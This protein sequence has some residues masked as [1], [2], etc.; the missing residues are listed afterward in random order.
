LAD[1]LGPSGQPLQPNPF[2]NQQQQNLKAGLTIDTS[3]SQRAFEDLE[4]LFKKMMRGMGADWDDVS[5]ASLKQQERLYRAIGDKQNEH[6]AMVTRIKNETLAAIEEEKHA[7]LAMLDQRASAERMTQEQ[8]EKE[9]TSIALKADNERKNIEDKTRKNLAKET[10]VGGLIRGKTAEV[11]AA[12]GGPIG[13]LISGAGE[14]LTNPYA[15]G[16]MAIFE[17]FKTKAAFTTTGAQLAGAGFGLGSGAGVGLDFAQKLFG[18]NPFGRL[19]QALSQGEQQ[20][21][22]AQMAG[23]RT[24]VDQ[25]RGGGFTAIRNNLG[26]FANILPDA[27]KDMEIMT[28]ATKNLGMSQ[29]DVTNAFVSSRVN[30]ERLKITQL[31][32]I[33]T[34]MDMAK[35]LRNL[36]ND[37]TVAASTLSNVT[38]YLNAIGASESEKQRIGLSIAQAGAN[39]TLPQMAGMFAFTNGRMPTEH[40]LFGTAATGFGPR[41]QGIVDNP[42]TL[43]GGF[44]AKVGDQFKNNPTARMF[45]ASQLQTQFLPGLRLQDTPRFFELAQDM[46]KGRI[47]Q[48]VFGK[49]FQALEEKTPQVA[50][51]EGIKTLSEIVDPIKRLENVFTNFWTMVDDK[52]NMVLQKFNITPVKWAGNAADWVKQHMGRKPDASHPSK[53][54]GTGSW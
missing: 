48:D 47:S 53:N 41:N 26:L 31:D 30:A 13:G 28:D 24:M 40:D 15:L 21:I 36:T 2:F 23:S 9:R 52:I 43:L 35:A 46:M 16:A 39:L 1:L 44:L 14:L 25:A 7:H 45:A 22:I 17:M 33:R 51:A 54:G 38:D 20:A 19:N 32:A 4:K 34:Q 11:G 5:N 8:I 29:R 27:A 6:R 3:S 18:A 12:V 50:M 37:G 49:R 42:F 10:G